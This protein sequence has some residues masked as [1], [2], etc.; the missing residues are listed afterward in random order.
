MVKYELINKIDKVLHCSHIVIG[1]KYLDS[2]LLFLP[3]ALAGNWIRIGAIKTPKPAPIL[4]LLSDFSLKIFDWF[5]WVKFFSQRSSYRPILTELVTTAYFLLYLLLISNIYEFINFLN[6]HIE[7][8]SIICHIFHCPSKCAGQLNV[9]LTWKLSRYN[10]IIQDRRYSIRGCSQFSW[11]RFWSWQCNCSGSFIC[12]DLWVT[13]R[14]SLS[15]TNCVCM[16]DYKEP[17]CVT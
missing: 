3:C 4:L 10:I 13:L 15:E 14:I 6:S 12:L 7:V 9:I 8:T 1:F 5:E 17:G 16:L 2:F 11:S